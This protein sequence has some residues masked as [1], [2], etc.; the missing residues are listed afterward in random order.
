MVVHSES[1]RMI[2]NLAVFRSIL[3]AA[4]GKVAVKDGHLWCVVYRKHLRYHDNWGIQFH[5][6]LV[7]YLLMADNYSSCYDVSDNAVFFC[8][9]F[10]P[11]WT[12][13]ICEAAL[14]DLSS[15]YWMSGDETRITRLLTWH[16]R[17]GETNTIWRKAK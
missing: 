3:V 17:C 7:Y 10:A 6:T 5:Y 9:C 1:F 16:H 2:Y 4:N 13:W 8:S 11:S 15:N 12:L 14:T